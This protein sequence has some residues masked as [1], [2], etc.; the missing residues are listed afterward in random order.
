[1]VVVFRILRTINHC[2]VHAGVCDCVGERGSDNN[3]CLL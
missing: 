2:F 3:R 1:M